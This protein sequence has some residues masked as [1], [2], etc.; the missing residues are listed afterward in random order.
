MLVIIPA[1]NEGETVGAVIARVRT[2]VPSADILVID[3]GSTDHTEAVAR[4]AGALVISLP[5]NLGIGAAT[6]TGYVFGHGMGYDLVARIDADGQHDPIEIPRL[7]SA[8]SEGGAH[9]VVG[10]R[11]VSGGEYS[12]SLLRRLGAWF[13]AALISLIT[14]QKMT[15][16]TSGFEVIGREAVAVYATQY[17]HDYPEPESRVL[18]YRAGLKVKEVSVSSNPRRAGRS[19]IGLLDSVYY[20]VR[21]TIALLVE[22]LRVTPQWRKRNGEG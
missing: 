7:M 5:H 13:L 9:V 12:T 10:S 18:L 22:M 6:Q 2:Y 1:H 3:D 11:F 14:G 8:L 19:S 4:E 17:P 15:D 21:I 20:M 16:P